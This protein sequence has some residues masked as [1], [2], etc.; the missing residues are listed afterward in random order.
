[1][2]EP[3]VITAA[4][5]LLRAYY[6]CQP[7]PQVMARLADAVDAWRAD[8]WAAKLDAATQRAIEREECND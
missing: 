5:D 2:T 6:T 1:M 7:L 4:R 8:E 3:T